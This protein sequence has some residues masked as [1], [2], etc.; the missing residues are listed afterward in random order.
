MITDSIE[1][2]R[3]PQ[4]VFDYLDQLDRHGEWQ[5]QIVS[6]ELETDGPTRVGSRA[7]ETRKMGGRE[8]RLRYEVTEHDPPRR[9]DF[10]GIDGPLRPVGKGTIEPIGDGSSSRFTLEFE[11]EGHGFGKLLAPF[12]L[13]QARKQI[14]QDHQQLKQRLEHNEESGGR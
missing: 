3:S 10:R 2:N 11:F 4:D 6:V 7:A 14:A 8:Q 13:R 5:S 9:F 1:I 12:A